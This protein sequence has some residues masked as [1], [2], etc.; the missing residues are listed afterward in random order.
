MSSSPETPAMPSAPVPA[1]SGDPTDLDDR[2]GRLA[3]DARRARRLR[4]AAIA[5]I[6]LATVGAGWAGW[7]MVAGEPWTT[8]PVGYSVKSAELTEVTFHVTKRAD[9]TLRCKV[10][11]LA[12][13]YAQV[14]FRE[15][16]IPPSSGE[17]ESFTVD[18]RTAELATT[19]MVESCERV[20]D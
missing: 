10:V 16:V 3:P 5:A 15:V 6:A 14:G 7:S 1:P 17:R 20:E 19:G 11:A 9:I 13:N 2:Y 4:A 12:E 18:V 8:K